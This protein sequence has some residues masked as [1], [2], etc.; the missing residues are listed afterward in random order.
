MV[1][2]EVA[3]REAVFAAVANTLLPAKQLVLVRSV[4]GVRSACVGALGY[5]GAV[6]RVKPFP[7]VLFLLHA[8]LDKFN[9]FGERSMPSHLRPSLSAAMS[10]VAQPQNGSSTRSPSLLDALIMRSKS[11]SGF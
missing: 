5:V 10:V 2:G 8:Y 6:Y 7:Q 9:R 3:E 1:H 4:V 11:A